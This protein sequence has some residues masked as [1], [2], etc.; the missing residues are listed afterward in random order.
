MRNALFTSW[1]QGG[2]KQ[3]LDVHGNNIGKAIVEGC[4]QCDRL[5]EIRNCAPLSEVREST[6]ILNKWSKMNVMEAKR[7]F[8]WKKEKAEIAGHFNEKL[9]V[10]LQ[11]QLKVK[12]HGVLGFMPA[13]ATHMQSI[14]QVMQ[15]LKSEVLVSDISSFEWIANVHVIFNQILMNTELL[16][17]KHNI[18]R[19][20]FQIKKC[21]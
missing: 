10:P 2:K 1:W 16:I 3:F 5:H 20:E 21:L 12:S 7:R 19:Y 15:P 18:A 4:F 9:G 6:V 13:V 14:L 17:H 8:S 11:K